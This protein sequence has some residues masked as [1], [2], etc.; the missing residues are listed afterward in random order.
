MGIG[1]PCLPPW[2]RHAIGAYLAAGR[3][4]DAERIVS[5]LD[6]A[7]G[8]LPAG[9][10]ASRGTG[11]A[12]LAELR[13]T[14]PRPRPSSGPRW[15]C[16]S[17]SPCHWSTQ[18]HCWPTA[19][20]CAGPAG[21]PRPDPCWPVP[22]G[23]PRPPAPAGWPGWHAPSFKVA[24][25]RRQRRTVPG[26]LTSQEQ[27][28]ADLA[29]AGAAN[30]DIARQLVLVG[31]HRRDSSRARL[32]QAWH[33]LPFTSSS[34]WPPTPAGAPIIRDSPAPLHPCAIAGWA[35]LTIR[36]SLRNAWPT[37]I[38]QQNCQ[39]DVASPRSIGTRLSIRSGDCRQA[40]PGCAECS[41]VFLVDSIICLNTSM[42]QALS[43][44]RQ[45]TPWWPACSA[46]G[47]RASPVP[48]WSRPGA[49]TRARSGSPNCSPAA[50][51]P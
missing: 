14:P 11:R 50:S 19:R 29:A 49:C 48:W 2:P 26:A 23:W 30:A 4:A 41:W 51:S 46:S 39:P 13:E 3:T 15:C 32:R 45:F 21:R 34:R 20:S 17:R 44:R 25:G 36:W 1:E 38:R 37:R 24:G 35:P 43:L 8:P 5:W 9:S 6:R 47:P 28:V 22:P 7:A 10:P 31:Q 16:T 40:C 33:P 27:R 42:I 18:R 12:Q